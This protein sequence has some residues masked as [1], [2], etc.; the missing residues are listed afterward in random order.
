[1]TDQYRP[2]PADSHTVSSGQPATRTNRLILGR[3]QSFENA[4]RSAFDNATPAIQLILRVSIGL[5]VLWATIGAVIVVGAVL[6]WAPA[7]WVGPTAIVMWTLLALVALR[8]TWRAPSTPLPMVS[9]PSLHWV[10]ILGCAAAIVVAVRAVIAV[11][12]TEIIGNGDNRHWAT[13]HWLL[14]RS[15]RSGS[16]PTSIPDVVYPYGTSFFTADGALPLAV[17]TAWSVVTN[18]ATLSFNLAIGTAIVTT[19]IAAHRLA[20]RLSTSRLIRCATAVACAVAPALS[21][22]WTFYYNLCFLAPFVVWMTI[23]LDVVSG[24]R[25]IKPGRHGAVLALCFLSSGY[26]FVFGGLAS[27]LFV[28]STRC[29]LQWRR[30]LV[31]GVIAL[32]LVSPFLTAQL[33]HQQREAS[34]GAV[35]IANESINNSADPRS[36]LGAPIAPRTDRPTNLYELTTSP[37]VVLIVGVAL[38]VMCPHPLRRPIL[39]SIAGLW[40]LTLGPRLMINQDPVVNHNW[41]PF[42]AL[43]RLPGMDSVRGPGRLALIAVP[44][45]AMAWCIGAEHVRR[46]YHGVSRALLGAAVVAALCVSVS[47]TRFTTPLVDIS[48]EMQSGLDRVNGAPMIALPDDCLYHNH[49]MTW[50]TRGA[51]PMAGCQGFSAALP[52]AS[53]LDRYRASTA[54]AALRC[55]PDQLVTV[56][57]PAF[58]A[59]TP[60]A[61][62]VRSLRTQLGVDVVLFDRSTVCP[63]NPL[64][65]HQAEQALRSTAAV[66]AIDDEYILFRLP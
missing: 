45:A 1:V 15:I 10:E 56:S 40:L 62:A 30:V 11:A 7:I 34:A 12:T 47:T 39:T 8:I 18:E 25:S 49:L 13:L 46:Q 2:T 38:L 19:A 63:G 26:L 43:S 31:T 41:L 42:S 58:R 66:I 64:R 16:V 28:L 54:W 6:N 29:P 20:S 17:G 48:A 65:A 24:R 3:L 27:G 14:A 59:L 37:G 32:A 50:M 61:S 22:K 55:R 52:F 35:P 60:T 5:A 23:C 51:G 4:I 53:G 33:I 44:F 36:I 21:I 9:A 57:L